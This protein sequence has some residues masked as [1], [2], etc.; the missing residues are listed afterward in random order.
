MSK[1]KVQIIVFDRCPKI[2]INYRRNDDNGIK[3][4][5]TW[6]RLSETRE[7]RIIKTGAKQTL[8][9]YN[10]SRWSLITGLYP[11]SE[12]LYY[13]DIERTTVAIWIM[14]DKSQIRMAVFVGHKPK[15]KTA[16]KK[17]VMQFISDQ[18]K[19]GN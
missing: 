18:K 5:F 1:T 10:G 4:P 19:Q 12:N 8:E 6:F 3:L 7:A 9:Y 13:G 11:I 17:K 16:R 14:P 2:P 15:Y